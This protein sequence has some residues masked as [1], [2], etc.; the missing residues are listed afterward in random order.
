MD[1]VTAYGDGFLFCNVRTVVLSVETIVPILLHF[2]STLYPE[3]GFG[4]WILSAVCFEETAELNDALASAMDLRWVW[5]ASQLD[6]L[7]NGTDC[8]IHRLRSNLV[9][10]SIVSTADPDSK[11]REDGGLVPS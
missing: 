5:S 11:R 4:R 10:S 2:S 6:G 3:L 8:S 1:C 7:A 9:A